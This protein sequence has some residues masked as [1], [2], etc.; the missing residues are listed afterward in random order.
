[1]LDW[2]LGGPAPFL[3]QEPGRSEG[4]IEEPQPSHHQGRV[5][6]TF[7]TKQQQ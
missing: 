7:T 2:F 1:M 5:S 3:E 6:P 4:H